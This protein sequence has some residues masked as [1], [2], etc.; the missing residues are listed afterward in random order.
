MATVDTV[1]N[2]YNHRVMSQKDVVAWADEKILELELP[3]DEIFEELMNLSL[4]KPNL[5][6]FYYMRI[7][8]Y[9]DDFRFIDAFAVRV[10]ALD[11]ESESERESFISWVCSYICELLDLGSDS[12]IG[13]FE[14][15]IA[16]YADM[17]PDTREAENYF[18]QEVNAYKKTFV[19]L[20]GAKARPF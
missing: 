6:R 13:R 7:I 9:E 18:D 15:C 16:R 12:P 3:N 2:L 14:Y 19:S 17:L 10:C 4:L 8:D 20:G 1:W 11:L 5:E